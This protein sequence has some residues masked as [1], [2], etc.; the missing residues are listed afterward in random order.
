MS[1]CVIM[2]RFTVLSYGMYGIFPRR[3]QK[4]E[5]FSGLRASKMMVVGGDLQQM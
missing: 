4:K 2:G 1:L 5:I 3:T